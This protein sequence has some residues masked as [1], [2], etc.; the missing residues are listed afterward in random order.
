MAEKSDPLF[1]IRKLV[2][3]KKYRIR[4]HAVQHMI[5]EGFNEDDIVEALRSGRVLEQYENEARCLI[6]GSFT[7]EVSAAVPLHVLC[8][9]SNKDALD[10]VTAYIPQKPWWL[11]ETKRGQIQ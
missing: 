3:Q 5:K 6:L 8:D 1:R 10:I 9:H 2:E 7:T 11:T 4:I